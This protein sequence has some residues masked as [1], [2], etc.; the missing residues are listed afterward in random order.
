MNDEGSLTRSSFSLF[1]CAQIAIDFRGR[2]MI[3]ILVLYRSENSLWF[4][5]EDT[6]T[7]AIVI[8]RILSVLRHAQGGSVEIAIDFRG[9][10]NN[11]DLKC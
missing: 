1:Y 9:R 5:A 3:A 7:N 2:E 4:A 10:E 11:R 6:T 8:Y